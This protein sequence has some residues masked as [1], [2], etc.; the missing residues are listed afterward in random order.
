MVTHDRRM[1]HTSST[2]KIAGIADFFWVDVS[3]ISI[4]SFEFLLVHHSTLNP[5][6]QGVKDQIQNK[7]IIPT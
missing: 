4:A 1:L 6:L 3:F 5:G 2:H 7:L